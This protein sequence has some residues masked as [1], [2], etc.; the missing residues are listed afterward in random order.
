MYPPM[1]LF[2][3]YW[4]ILLS[5]GTNVK[6]VLDEHNHMFVLLGRVLFEVVP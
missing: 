6:K 4:K 3:E 1:C 2:D 5:T